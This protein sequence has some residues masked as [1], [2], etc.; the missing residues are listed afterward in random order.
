MNSPTAG[1]L[2]T[3]ARPSRILSALVSFSKIGRDNGPILRSK[4]FTALP[5][6]L[7]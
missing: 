7:H 6:G 1:G 5:G 2:F 3:A 4:C